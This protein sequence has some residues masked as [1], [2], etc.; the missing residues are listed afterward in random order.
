MS[1]AAGDVS[2]TQA[3]EE[4]KV[5]ETSS[6]LKYIELTH[7]DGPKPTKGQSAK[8]HYTLTLGGFDG[9]VVDSS[10]E[11][12]KP[13]R[14]NVGTGQ[15]IKGW[16]EGLMMMNVGSKWQ[17]IIPS[18]LGY[19]KNG[20]GGVIPPNATLYFLVELLGLDK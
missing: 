1:G 4:Q 13:F 2:E 15:V 16:D 10:F 11:R 8:V 3:G 17:L 7:G 5:Q 9:K 14:F 20:A 18:E 19:G 6:G 12:K